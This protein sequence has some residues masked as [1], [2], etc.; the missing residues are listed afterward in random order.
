MRSRTIVY[1]DSVSS[2]T[3][4]MSPMNPR[5]IPSKDSKLA[6]DV[7]ALLMR[8]RTIIFEFGID[9][10]SIA[11]AS[12]TAIEPPMHGPYEAWRLNFIDNEQIE[13]IISSSNRRTRKVQQLSEDTK[14]QLKV[15]K[16][17]AAASKKAPKGKAACPKNTQ[18]AK[19]YFLIP[20][21]IYHNGKERLEL[22]GLFAHDT[23]AKTT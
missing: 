15:H 5:V 22:C 3:L 16:R 23:C 14:K 6:E 11:E 13:P 8:S 20:Q 18:V 10:D 17:P 4:P 9:S 19:E 1:E 2:S 21:T 7:G 12:A